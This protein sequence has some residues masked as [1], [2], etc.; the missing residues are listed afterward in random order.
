MKELKVI[1]KIAGYGDRVWVPGNDR[2]LVSLFKAVSLW[3]QKSRVNPDGSLEILFEF[4]VSD[5]I[6]KIQMLNLAL[7]R[8]GYKLV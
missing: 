3:E 4:P 8:L 6:R 5:D 2:E 7:S 1:D